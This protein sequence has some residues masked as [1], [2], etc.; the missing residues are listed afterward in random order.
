MVS[1]HLSFETA[2]W[3]ATTL[4]SSCGNRRVIKRI[5]ISQIALYLTKWIYFE[6]SMGKNPFLSY[7]LSLHLP[8]ERHQYR[9]CHMTKIERVLALHMIYGALVSLQLIWLQLSR[10]QWT[11]GHL[12]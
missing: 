4:A 6:S 11:H 8:L 3:K 1:S 10:T 12:W 5:Q 7:E 2:V 9:S